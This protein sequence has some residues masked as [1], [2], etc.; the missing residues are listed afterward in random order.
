MEDRWLTI[1]L[2][3]LAF[4]AHLNAAEPTSNPLLPPTGRIEMVLDSDVYNEVDDQFALAFAV[5]SPARIDLRAVHAAPFL[6]HRSKSP[7][8]GMER[9][10]DEALRVLR[11][12]GADTDGRVF[13]GS[14]RFLTDRNTPVDSPAARRTPSNSRGRQAGP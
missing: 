1:A 8:E 7:G 5:R 11:L 9:S 13:R 12:L 14:P 2:V 3:S 10:Y 4:A 6:N